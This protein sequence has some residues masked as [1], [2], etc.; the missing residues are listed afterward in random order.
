M[1]GSDN[2]PDKLAREL[3]DDH[4]MMQEARSGRSARIGSRICQEGVLDQLLSY[5][6]GFNPDCEGEEAKTLRTYSGLSAECLSYDVAPMIDQLMQQSRLTKKL[7]SFLNRRNIPPFIAF[8]FTQCIHRLYLQHPQELS[9]FLVDQQE[10]ADGIRIVDCLVNH[11]DTPHLNELLLALIGGALTEQDTAKLSRRFADWWVQ[12]GLFEKLLDRCRPEEDEDTHVSVCRLLLEIVQRW[13]FPYLLPYV[14]KLVARD[15]LEDVL[16]IILAAERL[17]GCSVI[18]QEGMSFAN[19]VVGNIENIYKFTEKCNGSDDSCTYD[20]ADVYLVLVE[21]LDDFITILDTPGPLPPVPVTWGTSQLDPPLGPNRMKVAELVLSMVR[22]NPSVEPPLIEKG[23]FSRFLA[24]FEHYDMNNMFAALIDELLWI[25][26]QPT[27][28]ELRRHLIGECKLH[29]VLVR[30]NNANKQQLASRG[31]RKGHM[32]FVTKMALQLVEP[33]CE[34]LA[35]MLK[36]SEMWKDF[37]RDVLPGLQE[38]ITLAYTLSG[39]NVAKTN[40]EKGLTTTVTSYDEAP[41]QE[42]EQVN[43][44]TTP[45]SKYLVNKCFTDYGLDTD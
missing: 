34:V 33:S 2:D 8:F 21:H 23:F 40:L 25:S 22:S 19:T 7:F 10:D 9:Q 16:R 5:A 4:E 13:Q 14:R 3:L 44:Q 43:A 39:N 20:R 31:H 37:E 41:P 6:L 45:E 18:F 17:D 42:E 26:L 1:E 11:V 15:T 38:S 32:G 12:Q 30:C 36:S 35:E 27:R 24:L 28:L 29:E